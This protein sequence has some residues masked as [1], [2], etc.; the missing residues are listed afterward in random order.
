MREYEMWDVGCCVVALEFR[1]LLESDICKRYFRFKW[2]R[3]TLIATKMS[4][5]EHLKFKV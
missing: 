1:G 5:S 2:H 4:V 3:C